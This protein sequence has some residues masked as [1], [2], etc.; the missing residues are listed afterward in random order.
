VEVEARLVDLVKANR[1]VLIVGAGMH[2]WGRW[3]RGFQQYAVIAARAALADGNVRWPDIQFISAA[4]AIR[5][6]IAGVTAGNSISR[7]LGWQ[8]AAVQTSYGACVSGAQALAAARSRILSGECELAL[9]VGSDESAHGPLLPSAYHRP[10]D[11]E[12]VG[13]RMGLSNVVYLGLAAR[14]RMEV[15]GTTIDDFTR[16]K[17]KNSRHA[18]LNPNARFRCAFTHEQV[19]DSPIVCDP[20]RLF[21]LSSTSDGAAAVVLASQAYA[22][23]R[24][25]RGVAIAAVC[26]STPRFP[27][28][29]ILPPSVCSDSTVASPGREICADVVADA[30]AAA[31]IG[32]DDISFAEV[33]DLSSSEELEWYEHLGFCERGAA[34]VLLR[35]GES[36]LTGGRPVNPSGG[37]MSFGEA[38]SAQVLAQV[39]EL[40][41]QLRG[42]A[43]RRQVANARTAIAASRGAHGNAAAIVMQRTC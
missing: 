19:Q 38:S 33:Y 6:G 11:L 43:S 22:R 32:P 35:S 41:W 29:T 5:S 4:G 26:V 10:D 21:H 17:V 18:E 14:R 1:N 25:L 12:V 30:Y 8:G 40:V 27:N 3:G 34:E 31:G 13:H 36:S 7:A 15:F 39:C 9:V 16:V 42:T 37:L 28:S 23:R 2:P 20:L 24:G